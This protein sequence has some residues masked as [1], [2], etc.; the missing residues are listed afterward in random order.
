M[1]HRKTR[2]EYIPGMRAKPRPDA[3]ELADQLIRDWEHKHQAAGQ[4]E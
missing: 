4:K 3:A 2:G 1:T